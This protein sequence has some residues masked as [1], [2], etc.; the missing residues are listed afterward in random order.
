[1]HVLLELVKDGEAELP[2][3]FVL[4]QEEDVPVIEADDQDVAETY[5]DPAH[6]VGPGLQLDKAFLLFLIGIPEGKDSVLTGGVEHEL[7]VVVFLLESVQLSVVVR[8]K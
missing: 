2:S 3:V 8:L 7:T 5:S 1:M 6:Y 4:L